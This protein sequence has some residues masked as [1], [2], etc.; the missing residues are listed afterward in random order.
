MNHQ[1]EKIM[2]QLKLHLTLEVAPTAQCSELDPAIHDEALVQKAQAGDAESIDCLLCMY[3]TDFRRR[4]RCACGGDLAAAEDVCQEAC[5][6]VIHCLP[7]FVRGRSFRCWAFGFI[8]NEARRRQ[9]NLK[10]ICTAS[11][12][13]G[14][15]IIETMS[16]GAD[17]KSEADERE[18]LRF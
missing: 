4:A 10:R 15:D 9:R 6:K 18:I 11:Q 12:E 3:L 2:N 5:L 14:N 16:A 17:N 1:R 8:D 7:R 13:L